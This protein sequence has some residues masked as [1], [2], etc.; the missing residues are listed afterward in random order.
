MAL[1]EKL[2]PKDLDGRITHVKL[3]WE[4]DTNKQ[5]YDMKRLTSKIG[6]TSEP[7]IKALHVKSEMKNDTFYSKIGEDLNATRLKKP[8]IFDLKIGHPDSQY[9]FSKKDRNDGFLANRKCIE[10]ENYTKSNFFN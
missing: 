3:K 7:Y 1:V 8:K 5:H 6:F 4:E 2:D 10:G 9:N